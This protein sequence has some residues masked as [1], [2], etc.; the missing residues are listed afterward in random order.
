LANGSLPMAESFRFINPTDGW[1]AGGPNQE[2]YITHNAGDKWQRVELAAPKEIST[3]VSPVYGLPTFVNGKTGYLPVTYESSMSTGTPMALFKSEDAGA[4]WHC[5]MTTPPL[6]DAH[7]W[8]AYPSAVE[9]G[10]LLTAVISSGR[11]NLSSFGQGVEP[12]SQFA[13][14]SVRASNA[15]QLSFVS[16][17]RGWLL[18]TYWLLSTTDGGAT[19][20]DVTPEPTGTLPTPSSS[21]EPT[22]RMII[23]PAATRVAEGPSSFPAGA[24]VST[25][26]GFDTFPTAPLSTMQAWS[27]SSPFYDVYIYLYGSPN[28]TTVKSKYPTKSWLSTVEATYGW[29]V[30]PIWFGLQSTCINDTTNITQFIS[31]T[32]ATASTQGAEQADSAVAQDQLLGIANGIIYLDIESYTT[33]GACSAAVQAYVDGFVSE[34]GAYQGFSAGVYANPVPITKDISQVSPPPAAIWITKTPPKTNPVPSVTIWNQGMSD[35]LW[36]NGQRTH[37][38]LLNQSETFGTAPALNIDP[39]IDNG[40]VLNA[41]AMA[42]SYAYSAPGNIDCPGAIN[43]VPLGINDMNNGTFISGP[44]QMGTVVGY[45]QTSLTSPINGFQNTAGSCTSISFPGSSYT[46]AVGIN[47]LGE[48]V[49]FFEDSSGAFHGFSQLPGKSPTQI[50]YTGGGQTY[51]YGINDAGQIVGFAYS[52]ST[53]YYQ[54]FMYYG[55]VFYPLGTYSGNFEYTLGFGISGDAVLTGLYYYEPITEDFELSATP[56]GSGSNIVWGGNTIA[57]TPGGSANTVAHAINANNEQAGIYKTT[58]C[59]DTAYQC[60]FVWT[61]G[62]TLDVLQYGTDADVVYGMND[63]AEAVGPYTDSATQYSHGLLWT[64]Q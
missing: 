52:P 55:G 39:D 6:P 29:G 34:I 46:E 40:P 24:N 32:P 43:T 17:Q 53:F 13:R 38:F 51:L 5:V 63:F 19:W 37:Q 22:R 1:L 56:S 15:D 26:L 49:G 59:G 10:G 57:L 35:L 2:L 4:T 62:F 16:P 14:I 54:T 36:P 20:T 41:N 58:A 48:I 18:A 8:T 21:S 50:D 11:I 44:G 60:G 30:I 47:N 25:H 31:T 27:N 3:E 28:K 23:Q 33:G 61:G 7:P 42:K 12:K 9:S 45:F 64:H